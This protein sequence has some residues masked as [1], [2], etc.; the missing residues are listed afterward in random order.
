MERA[1]TSGASP[2]GDGPR[3]GQAGGA[4]LAAWAMITWQRVIRPFRPLIA[5]SP[6]AAEL[7]AS[8][9]LMATM[10]RCFSSA[11][12][13]ALVDLNVPSP[14]VLDSTAA[15]EACRVKLPNW[16]TLELSCL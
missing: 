7:R 6:K 11:D 16:P 13:L 9:I 15:V 1:A 3:S 4:K 5:W 14:G 12:S 8:L 2:G 10:S